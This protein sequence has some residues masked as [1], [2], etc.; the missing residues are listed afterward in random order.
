LLSLGLHFAF[1]VL[2]FVSSPY[3]YLGVILI[4]FGIII[5]LWTDSL[6]KKKQTT[7]KPHEMPNFFIDSGPFR[8]SRHPMYLGMMSILLGVAIFL[9]SLITFV[10]PIVFIIIMERNFIP[11]EEKNLIKKFGNRYVDYRKNVRRWI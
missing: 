3:Y 4:L 10:F 7:V 2:K 6:F 9:G 11:M 1:P 8:L 5:N